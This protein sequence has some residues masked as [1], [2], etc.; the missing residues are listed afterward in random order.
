MEYDDMKFGFVAMWKENRYIRAAAAAVSQLL[1]CLVICVRALIEWAPGTGLP[2]HDQA[3]VIVGILDPDD[4]TV[5]ILITTRTL[6]L[7]LFP[8]LETLRIRAGR[9]IEQKAEEQILNWIYPYH[10]DNLEL[11]KVKLEGSCRSFLE[12]REYIEWT[13]SGPSALVCTGRRESLCAFQTDNDAKLEPANRTLCAFVVRSFSDIL[14]PLS[15]KD[16][17]EIL[18]YVLHT[19]SSA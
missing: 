15:S 16:C 5:K 19:S 9:T 17:C 18:G 12:S 6:F 8:T 3:N 1:T 13:G 11:S 4:E 7:T 14:D 2:S 10:W